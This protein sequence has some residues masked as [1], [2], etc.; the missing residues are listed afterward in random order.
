MGADSPLLARPRSGSLVRGPGTKRHR[1]GVCSPS[2]RHENAVLE[3]DLGPAPHTSLFSSFAI[4][5]TPRR[6]LTNAGG[7]LLGQVMEPVFHDTP[8]QPF[9]G[10][11]GALLGQD[12]E[13]L[14]HLS[15]APT[16]TI[17]ETPHLPVTSA[18]D[19]LL[20]QDL[21]QE[22]H[23]IYPPPFAIGV[24]PQLPLAAAGR[25]R[26]LAPPSGHG[27]ACESNT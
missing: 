12:V 7:T 3:Q 20:G 5:G 24:I 15:F 11:G 18:D 9:A 22:P 4:E 6:P 16:L 1:G 10:A 19:A 25:A 26:R 13:P 14:L 2:S 23:T 21:D 8:P 27:R 17:D